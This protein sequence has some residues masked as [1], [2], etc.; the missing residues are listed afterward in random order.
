PPSANEQQEVNIERADNW[1]NVVLNM[2]NYG[3][4]TVTGLNGIRE[5]GPY[6]WEPPNYFYNNTSQ[7]LARGFV[8]EASVGPM[9]P[10]TESMTAG[11]LEDPINYPEDATWD[12]HMGG[13]PFTTLSVFNSAMSS[14]Y[15][16]PTNSADYMR[17][18]MV[19]DY[20]GLNGGQGTVYVT[21]DDYNTHSGL[22]ATVDVL[23]F[24]LSSAY[25]NTF[26]V[27]AGPASS[28]AV[29]KLPTIANLSTTYFI[30]LKL[31]DSSNNV[32]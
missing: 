21:N 6:E 28:T 4:S 32:V 23:N 19:M 29:V 15:G 3:T 8:D 16:A 24:N 14:R 20:G 11:L 18:A 13:T 26:A 10:P 31:T 7:G 22:T 25:H 2:A 17:K 5:G 27:T 30:N 9:I 12:Y 1:P